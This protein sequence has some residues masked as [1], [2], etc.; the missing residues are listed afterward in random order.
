M[1]RGAVLVV[2]AVCAWSAASVAPAGAVA[3][4]PP[5]AACGAAPVASTFTNP[6]VI[7]IPDNSTTG[8]QGAVIVSGKTGVVRDVDVVTNV[9]HTYSSDLDMTI[10]SPAGTVVTLTTDNGLDRDN[11]FAGTTWDD[12]ADPA[13]PIPYAA[14][15]A[16]A[17]D[18][19]YTNLVLAS[20]LAP[21]EALG[22]FKGENPNGLWVLKVIDD[23][24]MDTGVVNSWALHL[25]TAPALQTASFIKASTAAAT[26]IPD[27]T[28][29][30][31]VSTIAIAGA[32]RYLTHLVLATNIV[33]TFASDLDVTLTSPQGTVATLT[34]DNGVD[35]DNVF[36]GTTWYDQADPASPI[37]YTGNPGQVGDHAYTTLVTA[38][39]LVPEEP[40]S[41]FDGENPNGTW[42]LKV[43]DDSPGE[44]GMLN[45]WQLTGLA[46]CPGVNLRARN[47]SVREGNRGSKL[48]SVRVVLSAPV[49]ESVTV[50]YKTANGTAKARKDYRAKS[51]VLTF[52]PGQL[53][54]TVR[55]RVLGDRKDERIE[56]FTLRLSDPVGATLA[57]ARASVAIRD[58][59]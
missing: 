43:V 57:R 1:R 25:Q 23:G 20:P 9:T 58:N 4:P 54:K 14:N 17:Q 27:N 22:A 30:G 13:S 46:A 3:P 29:A 18:H 34:T 21:E 48:V 47:A 38:T 26:A 52:A 37:P 16:L 10:T 8:V 33:H 28:A 6:V 12:Q 41:V 31:V 55:V 35:R 49:A 36:T 53:S 5:P 40:F 32:R 2:L 39:P 24:G 59:D 7:P 11:V 42:T 44:T 19:A 51:G 50:H 15:P 56:R 45:G